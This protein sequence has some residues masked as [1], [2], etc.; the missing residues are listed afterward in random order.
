MSTLAAP[1]SADEPLFEI[2]DGQRVQ[3]PPQGARESVLASYLA[4]LINSFAMGSI[5]VACI[6][7]LFDLQIGRDRPGP[8]ARFR[9]R[10]EAPATC[11][12]DPPPQATGW[13]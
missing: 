7:T 2:I 5:G 12:D 8:L 9:P 10:L 13:P 1:V 3:L 6:E 11:G 4:Y